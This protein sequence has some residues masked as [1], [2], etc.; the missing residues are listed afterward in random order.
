MK[1]NKLHK[2]LCQIAGIAAFAC[3]FFIVGIGFLFI[4]PVLAFYNYG[5][6]SLSAPPPYIIGYIRHMFLFM[7]ILAIEVLD[8]A[9][10]P[11]LIPIGLIAFIMD[12][13]VYRRPLESI[14]DIKAAMPNS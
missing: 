14:K 9:L 1:D 4:I 12:I 8:L 2:V 3:G 7:I 5:N 10:L 11:V 13:V 6:Y